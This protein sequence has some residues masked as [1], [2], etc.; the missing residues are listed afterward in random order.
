M[1]TC[2][3]DTVYFRKATQETSNIS[4]LQ[5]RTVGFGDAGD[6]TSF[7]I[8]NSHTIKSHLSKVYN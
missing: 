5:E 8:Y 2:L 1:N 6:P 4:C 7:L 3:Y